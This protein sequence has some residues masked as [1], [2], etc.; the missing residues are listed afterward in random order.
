MNAKGGWGTLICMVHP[1]A[2]CIA[3]TILLYVYRNAQADKRMHMNRNNAILIIQSYKYKNLGELFVWLNNDLTVWDC[4][5]EWFKKVKGAVGSQYN[6]VDPLFA[7][8]T[9][10]VCMNKRIILKCIGVGL[11]I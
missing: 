4:L 5:R 10:F 9:T 1:F 6:K 7:T 3:I 8:A 2:I 11:R